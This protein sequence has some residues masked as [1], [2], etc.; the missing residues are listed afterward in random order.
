MIRGKFWIICISICCLLLMFFNV[1]FP[2]LSG[3]RA[4]IL[5]EAMAVLLSEGVCGSAVTVDSVVGR[6]LFKGLEY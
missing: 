1:F 6:G 5:A 2:Y 3:R 4:D